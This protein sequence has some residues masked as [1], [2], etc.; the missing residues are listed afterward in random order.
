MISK[1]KQFYNT[2]V[3]EFEFKNT[4]AAFAALRCLVW[5][6]LR[7]TWIF[8]ILH[9]ICYTWFTKNGIIGTYKMKN[10]ICEINFKT[11]SSTTLFPISKYTYVQNIGTLSQNMPREWSYVDRLG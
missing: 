9:H 10:D 3:F 2:A 11:L 4:R 8:V 5:T 1:F 6:N 7:G